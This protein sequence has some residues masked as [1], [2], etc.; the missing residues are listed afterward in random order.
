MC[1][2]RQSRLA[3]QVECYY[4][5]LVMNIQ[6]SIFQNS[7]WEAIIGLEVHAQLMTRSKMF[8]GCPSDYQS[9]DPNT[10]VCPVCIAMPGSLPV[11]NQQAVEFVIMTGLALNC[12]IA[13][14]THFDS[15]PSSF[16]RRRRQ[17]ATCT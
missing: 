14:A 12:S 16:G 6:S 1:E 13:E 8:C 2:V 9:S 3:P 10:R 5:E 17:V 15:Y 7:E 4:T 11:I